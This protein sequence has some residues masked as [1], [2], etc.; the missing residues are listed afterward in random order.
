MFD[1]EEMTK[2]AAATFP[3]RR[4][5]GLHAFAAAGTVRP[6]NGAMANLIRRPRVDDV[7]PMSS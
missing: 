1:V 4:G 3:I 2:A 5:S 6:L 7:R